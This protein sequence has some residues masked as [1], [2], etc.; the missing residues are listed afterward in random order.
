MLFSALK[1]IFIRLFQPLKA[2]FFGAYLHKL[3]LTLFN[4]QGTFARFASFLI[5]P[6]SKFIVKK[7]FCFRKTFFK[8]CSLCCVQ[9][10]AV[11]RGLAN[12]HPSSENVKHFFHFLAS[13]LFFS[14]FP[15]PGHAQTVEQGLPD[16][17]GGPIVLLIAA[18]C[19]NGVS[20]LTQ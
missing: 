3:F 16:W 18:P 19:E 12:I 6:H 20:P 9:I 4:F 13:F 14:L 7:K 11:P 15:P 8:L 17:P 5:L 2:L 10:G 1:R